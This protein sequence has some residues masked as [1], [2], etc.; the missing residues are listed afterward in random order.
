MKRVIKASTG[1]PRKVAVFFTSDGEVSYDVYRAIDEASIILQSEFGISEPEANK[2]SGPGITD[3][4]PDIVIAKLEDAKSQGAFWWDPEKF[5]RA[6]LGKGF[7]DYFGREDLLY[8]DKAASYVS[9]VWE[10][11]A[12]KYKYIFYSVGE[13]EGSASPVDAIDPASVLLQYEFSCEPELANKVSGPDI[14]NGLPES[15]RNVLID[16]YDFDEDV[17]REDLSE[18]FWNDMEL[19]FDGYV[20]YYD[21]VLVSKVF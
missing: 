20:D 3:G 11:S 10:D 6:E 14:V 5:D 16:D 12:T 15:V 19:F 9:L 4:L 7:D 18:A 8:D 13:G 1:V 21:L 17:T 2:L